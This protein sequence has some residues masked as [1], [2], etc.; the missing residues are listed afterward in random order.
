M[1]VETLSRP[2]RNCGRTTHR[3]LHD[4]N[5]VGLCGSIRR[6]G[7]EPNGCAKWATTDELGQ[8]TTRY[9]RAWRN[10]GAV[11]RELGP[12]SFVAPDGRVLPEEPPPDV[13]R[14]AIRLRE[15]ET[16]G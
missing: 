7:Y 9:V 15:I 11:A 13:K 16:G 5:G 1:D 12:W 8:P 4:G 6:P 2:C 3:I 10:S 14:E